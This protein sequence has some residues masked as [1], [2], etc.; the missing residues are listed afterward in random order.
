MPPSYLPDA[1]RIPPNSLPDACR[2]PPS[3]LPDARR[4]PPSYLPDACGIPPSYLPDACRIPPNNLPDACRMPPQLSAGRLLCHRQSNLALRQFPC[5]LCGSGLAPAGAC[6]LPACR[7]RLVLVP[8]M[9][10]RHPEIHAWMARAVKTCGFQGPNNHSRQQCKGFRGLPCKFGTNRAPTS[11]LPG[12]YRTPAGAHSGP[13]RRYR[14]RGRVG[15]D[16][17]TTW[18]LSSGLAVPVYR[19]QPPL[20]V[21]AL[22]RPGSKRKC[23]A[24]LASGMTFSR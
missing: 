2:M 18:L 21:A 16:P 20:S 7:L 9:H 12:T 14:A 10:D 3:Y 1:C 11:H 13:R 4:M 17:P 8:L 22:C 15:R 19:A 23:L 6:L 5:S 24:V